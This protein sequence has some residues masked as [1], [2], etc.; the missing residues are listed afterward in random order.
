MRYFK[1]LVKEQGYIERE[2]TPYDSYVDYVIRDHISIGAYWRGFETFIEDDDGQTKRLKI[3]GGIL[4]GG[5][6]HVSYQVQN[7]LDITNTTR[8]YQLAIP[9]NEEQ[10]YRYHLT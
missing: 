3:L 9:L 10:N 7:P 4:I 6:L 1:F 2:L 8:V 5:M